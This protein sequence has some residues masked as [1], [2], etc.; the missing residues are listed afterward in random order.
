METK[1]GSSLGL[2]FFCEAF[3]LLQRWVCSLENARIALFEHEGKILHKGGESV[4]VSPALSI[5]ATRGARWEHSVSEAQMLICVISGCTLDENKFIEG[6]TVILLIWDEQN[7]Y[8][9]VSTK[10]HSPCSFEELHQHL[11]IAS[12]DK[13]FWTHHLIRIFFTQNK[14]LQTIL[15][16]WWSG[17]SPVIRIMREKAVWEWCQAYAA[18]WCQA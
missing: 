17:A 16:I 11:T 10:Y 12:K 4:L 8:E 18:C 7:I 13:I 14:F 1:R 6:A 3:V 9:G 15:S 5:S 2:F